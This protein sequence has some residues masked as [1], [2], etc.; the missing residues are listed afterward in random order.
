VTRPPPWWSAH[1]AG[2]IVCQAAFWFGVVQFYRGGRLLDVMWVATTEPVMA[3]FMIGLFMS[4]FL[5]TVLGTLWHLGPVENP[6]WRW[7]WNVIVYVVAAGLW[8]LAAY[9][10]T[11]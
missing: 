8:C 11:H 10:E 9:L 7:V 6:W 3:G 1:V 2:L 4:P 5:L